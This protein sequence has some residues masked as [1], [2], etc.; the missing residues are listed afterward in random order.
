MATMSN[1]PSPAMA[2]ALERVKAEAARVIRQMAD[3]DLA[4]IDT[5]RLGFINK[6][7]LVLGV[8]FKEAAG[9]TPCEIVARCNS[10]IE[11]YSDGRHADAW[12]VY[13]AKI[14]I[15]SKQVQKCQLN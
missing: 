11:T 9:L 15:S 8:G 13:W 7:G 14:I 12:R 10:A 2:E 3:R 6:L 5:D 1:P 4:W